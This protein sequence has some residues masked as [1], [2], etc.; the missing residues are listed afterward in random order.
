[1]T[2]NEK[3]S[4]ITV[5]TRDFDEIE[6]SPSEIITFPQGIFAFEEYKDYI[7]ISPLG[8][9]KCPVWLQSTENPNLCFI[10]FD[11]LEFCAD[12]QVTVADEDIAVLEMDDD[13]DAKF[14][15][16]SVIPENNMD[17]TVNLKSPIIINTRNHKAAQVIAANDYPIKFPVFAK[18]KEE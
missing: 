13:R 2:M 16:I 11:P 18:D 3:I 1:M 14:Y 12:Y 7:L 6:V 8:S 17:A 9:G 5:K 10:L 4:R 15:V